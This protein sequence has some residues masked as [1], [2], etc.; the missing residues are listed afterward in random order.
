MSINVNDTVRVDSNLAYLERFNSMVGTVAKV[1]DCYEH[2]IAIVEFGDGQLG[3]IPLDAL[4]KIETENRVPPESITITRSEFREAT[5][6]VLNP[7]SYVSDGEELG[8]EHMRMSMTAG[9]VCGRLERILFGA[10]VE[11]A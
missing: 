4:V 1:Y 7:W 5:I 11:N 10:E 2:H 9:I 8:A 6:D 3:K